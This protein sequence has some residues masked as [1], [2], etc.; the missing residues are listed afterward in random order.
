MSTIQGHGFSSRFR[1]SV[2]AVV[3]V[4]GTAFV[5]IANPTNAVTSTVGDVL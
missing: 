1:R 2:R 3:T 5:G 4:E